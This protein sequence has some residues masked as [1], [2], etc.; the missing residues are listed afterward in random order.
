MIRY[1]NQ[2]RGS[3]EMREEGKKYK[4]ALENLGSNE[5]VQCLFTVRAS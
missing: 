2:I 5:Y 3:R 1:E 4:G